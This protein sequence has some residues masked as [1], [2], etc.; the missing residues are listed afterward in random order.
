M[1]GDMEGNPKLAFSATIS[2]AITAL[3]NA[4]L[5]VVKENKSTGV[6]DWLKNTFGHH[7]IGHGIVTLIVFIVI[8]IIGMFVFKKEE[9]DD[10]TAN[11]MVIL[12]FVFTL[13][14]VAIIA[15]FFLMEL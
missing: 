9:I 3:F 1:R 7:W 11:L 13:I 5:V 8:T 10:K 2:Y 15:G 4:I 6:Y 12:I 14:S